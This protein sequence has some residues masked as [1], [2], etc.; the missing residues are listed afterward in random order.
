MLKG[1]FLN[2]LIPSMSFVGSTMQELI[3]EDNTLVLDH[4]TPAF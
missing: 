1:L 2:K 4:N 3:D